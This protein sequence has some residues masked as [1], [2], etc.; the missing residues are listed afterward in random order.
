MYMKNR[1]AHVGCV[2]KT[3]QFRGGQDTVPMSSLIEKHRAVMS[4]Y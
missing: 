4:K 3:L 1:L 2:T